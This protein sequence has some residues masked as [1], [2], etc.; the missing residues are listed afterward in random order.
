MDTRKIEK[1]INTFGLYILSVIAGLVLLLNP[2]GATALVTKLI[3]WI[4]VILGAVMLIR[5]A[6][7][8]PSEATLLSQSPA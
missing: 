4:L 8:S 7:R 1:F 3:G 6:L 5:P 2:D